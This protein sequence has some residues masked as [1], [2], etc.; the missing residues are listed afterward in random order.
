MSGTS[1]CDAVACGFA[2]ETA[3]PD[4]RVARCGLRRAWRARADVD[5]KSL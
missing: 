4:R 2:N 5:A 3:A 1:L